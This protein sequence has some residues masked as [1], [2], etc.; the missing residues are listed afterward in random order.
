M[1]ELALDDQRRGAEQA[2]RGGV[3]GDGD[4]VVG[5]RHLGEARL[6]RGAVDVADGRELAEEVEEAWLCVCWGGG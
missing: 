2:P 4:V 5:A 6:E 1:D 3:L